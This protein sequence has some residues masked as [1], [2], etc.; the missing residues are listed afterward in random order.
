[1][2]VPLQVFENPDAI[3]V[4]LYFPSPHKKILLFRDYHYNNITING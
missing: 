2:P 4:N 1:M 3:Q